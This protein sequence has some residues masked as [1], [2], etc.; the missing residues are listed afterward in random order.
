VS[1]RLTYT[2]RWQ[3]DL[4]KDHALEV[5]GEVVELHLRLR[6]GHCGYRGDASCI[7]S[8]SKDV[9]VFK[10]AWVLSVNEAVRGEMR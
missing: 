1:A 7:E 4:G 9:E 3:S 6:S 5:G 2:T 10:E 8:R